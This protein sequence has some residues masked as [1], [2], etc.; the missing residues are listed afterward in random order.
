[1]VAIGQVTYGAAVG[2]GEENQGGNVPALANL[3]FSKYV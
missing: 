3:L 2:L 1:V